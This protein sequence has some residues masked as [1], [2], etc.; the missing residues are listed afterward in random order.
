LEDEI[1]YI[2]NCLLHERRLLAVYRCNRIARDRLLASNSLIPESEE[3]LRILQ[4]KCQLFEK[5]RGKRKHHMAALLQRIQE[6]GN[7]T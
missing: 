5:E 3:K 1:D 2:E 6:L 7:R 4:S